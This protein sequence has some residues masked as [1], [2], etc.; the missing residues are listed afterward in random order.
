MVFPEAPG[1][2]LGALAWHSCSKNA[3]GSKTLLSK[4]QQSLGMSSDKWRGEVPTFGP[5][6]R[7]TPVQ[8]KGPLELSPGHRAAK[9]P[10]A[11]SEAP[12][13]GRILRAAATP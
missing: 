11:C 2:G 1:I 13:R 3:R 5:L 12:L 4:S 7:L 6:S 9:P 8:R 10:E